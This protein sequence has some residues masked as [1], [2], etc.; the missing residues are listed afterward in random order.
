MLCYVAVYQRSCFVFVCR[1]FVFECYVGHRDLHVLTHSF[2]TRRSSDRTRAKSCR[3]TSPRTR[4]TSRP[5]TACSRAWCAPSRTASPS[6]RSRGCR[7][8][9]TRS[10]EHTSELQSRMR[11]SYAV[12]CLKQIKPE[13]TSAIMAHTQNEGTHQRITKQSI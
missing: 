3:C 5:S 10:E 13:L 9:S 2:P 12:F 8:S 7:S 6:A 1:G 11:S 4:R